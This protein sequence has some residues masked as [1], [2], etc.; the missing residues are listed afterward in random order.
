MGE[1]SP[2]PFA[3]VI[4]GKA[5]LGVGIDLNRPVVS[6][7]L[8]IPGQGLAIEF[9]LGLSPNTFKFPDAAVLSW[10]A[11]GVDPAWGFRSATEKYYMMYHH[12][13]KAREERRHMDAVHRHYRCSEFP[14]LRFMFTKH[15]SDR[16]EIPEIR[17]SQIQIVKSESI[18]SCMSSPGIYRL[19]AERRAH[20]RCFGLRGLPIRQPARADT[21]LDRIRSLESV[22][23]RAM[24]APWFKTGWALSYTTNPDPE[25]GA[26]SRFDN[27]K[28]TV[29]DPALKAGW[30]VFTSIP[31]SISGRSISITG[32]ITLTRRTTRCASRQALTSPVRRSGTMLRV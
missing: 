8:Y 27:Q 12:C 26:G 9:D 13:S 30:T 10:V 15:P 5:G 3:C 21:P 24:N 22:V 25:L 14:R 18:P 6:R 4:S 32:S 7:I 16:R 23:V 2:Y 29:I 28:K 11:F 19:R 17:L 31:G 20:L 1:F